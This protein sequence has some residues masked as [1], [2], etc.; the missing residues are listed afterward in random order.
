MGRRSLITSLDIGTSYVRAIIG[1]ERNPGE[2]NIIGIGTT[3]S[4]GMKEG[5]I[6]DL[7]KTIDAI[8]HAVEQAET[9]AG[10]EVNEVFVNVV[11]SHVNLI[12]N[13]GVVAVGRDDREITSEDVERVIQA[14]KVVSLPPD[15]EIV[16][17]IPHQFIVD[18]YD[19]IKDPVGMLGV[20]LEV[21]AL[22]VAGK[23]TAIHNMLRCV[24][25]A[26]LEVKDLVLSSMANAEAL[27]SEEEKKLGVALVD[28]GG[29]TVE[30][31]IFKDGFLEDIGNVAIGGDYITND[32]AVGL[33]ISQDEAEKLK[34]KFG[35]ASAELAEEGSVEI[36]S[37]GDKE[38]REVSI[39]EIGA[40]I[41][42]R[43]RE[44]FDFI[45]KNLYEYGGK[46]KLRAGIVLTGGITELK[47]LQEIAEEEL[48][49]NVRMVKPRLLGVNN[50][51]YS[52]G[53]GIIQ[54]VVNNDYEVE[55]EEKSNK[56]VSGFFQRIKN[57]FLDFFE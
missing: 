6:I 48:G 37:I 12:N 41:E 30:V 25:R 33:K 15:K 43:V 22:V 7:D 11:A 16:D 56:N 49:M 17:V 5:G 14:A 40:I 42:P 13:K 53:V 29:G 28:M 57:W 27:L 52:T 9:M 31:S 47:G 34:I 51:I 50:P 8:E 21:D 24:E 38:P 23:S 44:I 3:P 19:G 1:D 55:Y 39:E 32:L 18:G 2:I 10:V 35:V 26:G 36:F 20:R 46:N 45:D 54:Y 4:K